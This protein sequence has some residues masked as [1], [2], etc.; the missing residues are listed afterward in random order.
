MKNKTIVSSVL[1]VSI[2]LL[3]TQ[4]VNAEDNKGANNEEWDKPIFIKGADLEGQELQ[5]TKDDLNV[6][7]DFETYSVNVNDVS[8]YVPSSGNLSYIYSSATIEKSHLEV[9]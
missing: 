4:N 8:K 7:D 6:K 9:A 5:E 2:A 3:A 1:S